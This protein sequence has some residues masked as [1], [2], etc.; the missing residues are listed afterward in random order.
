MFSISCG[1]VVGNYG[2]DAGIAVGCAPRPPYLSCGLIPYEYSVT[3]CTY[4]Y[5][6]GLAVFRKRVDYVS[7]LNG[8]VPVPYDRLAAEVSQVD[9]ADASGF[10]SYPQPVAAV[11]EYRRYELGWQA[12][13]YG[14][15]AVMVYRAA[16]CIQYIYTMSGRSGK[17]LS[18]FTDRQFH[19]FGY[20]L[21]RIRYAPVFKVDLGVCVVICIECL[22]TC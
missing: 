20:V 1:Y 21:V 12:F 3:M 18:F 10:S 11:L 13:V 8:K 16:D 22:Q 14:I 6:A 7:G 2:H 5:V 4:E 15:L 17:N 9:D 19:Q